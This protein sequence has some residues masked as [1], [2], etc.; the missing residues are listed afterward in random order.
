MPKDSPGL[1]SGMAALL[2]CPSLPRGSDL[3][4]PLL[5]STAR[6]SGL[7]LYLQGRDGLPW[8]GG[9]FLVCFTEFT[10]GNKSDCLLWY[11]LKKRVKHNDYEASSRGGQVWYPRLTLLCTSTERLWIGNTSGQC[12]APSKC[13][14]NSD[15]IIR[16]WESLGGSWCCTSQS[17]PS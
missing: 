12:L 2:A 9:W 6:G 5:R 11:D 16:T 8:E 1:S 15:L 10:V 7:H 3:E 17:L 14:M 4:R 13:S